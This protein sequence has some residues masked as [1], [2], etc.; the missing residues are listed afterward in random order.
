MANGQQIAEENHAAFLAW[1]T[2]NQTAIS[3]N[4]HRGKLRRFSRQVGLSA[5]LETLFFLI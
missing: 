5:L 3:G 2:S 4:V 1:S